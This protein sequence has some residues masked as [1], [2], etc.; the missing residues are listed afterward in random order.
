MRERCVAKPKHNPQDSMVVNFFV[1]DSTVY[2][3]ALQIWLVLIG[4]AHNRQTTTYG[5]LARTLGYTSPGAQF[6]S[7]SS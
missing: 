6:I 2:K 4:K 1:E 7:F 3:R 5:A